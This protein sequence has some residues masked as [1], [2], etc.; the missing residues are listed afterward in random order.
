MPDEMVVKAHGAWGFSAPM[1]VK[2]D[3]E[4]ALPFFDD[5]VF[6]VFSV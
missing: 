4:S 5:L 2:I 1:L 3:L 6:I